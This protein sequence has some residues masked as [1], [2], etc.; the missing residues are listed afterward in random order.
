VAAFADAF[1]ERMA[2]DI[3]ETVADGWM[4]GK[5]SLE[6]RDDL[7]EKADEFGDWQAER[8][9]RQEL[10]IATGEARNE[11][12]AEIGKVE[13][14]MHSGDFPQREG[15]RES[16]ANMDGKWKRPSEDWE[17]DYAAEGG[18]VEHE[19]VPGDSENGIGCR[20]QTLLVDPDEVDP[21]DHAGV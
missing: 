13:V 9:A 12:A 5:N 4:D 6:I 1:A 17:V 19:H 10:Q 8:I 15:A 14:W 2:D 20:C 18:G 21:D 7:Q 3:R 11:Y 16:H